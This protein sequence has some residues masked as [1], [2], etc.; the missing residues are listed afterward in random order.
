M[1]KTGRGTFAP[2]GER[3]HLIFAQG[4][5][6]WAKMRGTH[7]IIRARARIYGSLVKA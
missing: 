4:D 3:V 1:T 5:Q 6:T 2:P 7:Y